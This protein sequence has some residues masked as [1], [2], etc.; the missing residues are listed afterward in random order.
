M[1]LPS[2]D[3][4]C[5]EKDCNQL[6]F[7]PLECKCG[8]IFCSHHFHAH[9]ESCEKSR[10]LSEDELKKIENVSVCSYGGCK[11]R[12]IVPILCER[13]KK[14]YC[15]KH[16]HLQECKEKDPE[17]IA[18]E[19][20]KYA[21]PMRQ[22]NEAK[23]SIDK[24][25]DNKITE[26]KNKGKN[27]NMANKV[28]LMR[29]KNKAIGLKSIPTTDRIYFNVI[30]PEPENEKTTAVFVSKQWTLGRA[31]DA[32][33]QELKLQNNNNKT[34]EKKLRLFKKD[35][36]DIVSSSMS[37]GLTALLQNNVIIDGEDLIITYV[38]NDCV[39]FM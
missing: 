9:V 25:L 29:L 4:Q 19:K 39:K 34:N 37:T 31:I 30:H 10:F 36:N 20:E 27:K 6:D 13:C 12:I 21:A 24:E 35:G 33:A 16:R 28:Q 23:A 14:S 8:K 18:A 11:E 5:S 1:E 17:T 2:L 7:L 38:D 22:F 3:K 15:V 26:A 32:I